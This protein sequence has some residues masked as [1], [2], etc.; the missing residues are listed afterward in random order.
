[1]EFLDEEVALLPFPEC[2]ICFCQ[3]F[4]C[5]SIADMVRFR[6]ARTSEERIR[7]VQKTMGHVAKHKIWKSN[8]IEWTSETT[9]ED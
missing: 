9:R 6:D 1:M 4:R 2:F 7:I 8:T 5:M 3:E